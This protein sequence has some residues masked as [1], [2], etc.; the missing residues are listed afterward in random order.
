MSSEWKW[1][2]DDE[3]GLARFILDNATEWLSGPRLPVNWNDCHGSI[4]DRRALVQKLY[5]TLER[6]E[7]NYT[8]EKYHPD[9]DEQVVRTPDEILFSPREGTRLD[10]ALLFCGLCM[11]CDLIPVLVRTR[12]HAFAMVCLTH[13]RSDWNNRPVKQLT[14]LRKGL[15]K[16]A[17]LLRGW[18]D[19]GF[20]L[21]VECT[22]FARS[23]SPPAGHPEGQHRDENGLIPFGRAVE[24]GR[25]QFDDPDRELEYAIDVPVARDKGYN[26][27]QFHP[28]RRAEPAAPARARQA[29]RRAL[30]QRL[31][32]L[33]EDH[34]VASG[35]L[36]YA[37]DAVDRLRIKRRVE[38]LLREMEEVAD[39]LDRM[40]P[41][42]GG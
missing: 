6:Y 10:L 31:A 28:L 25:A 34:Q 9:D 8:P 13:R 33:T 37:R 5:E 19:G 11:G 3:K 41:G 17:D 30:E 26:S 1:L 23:R 29:R 18:I 2:K 20:Y 12:G 24:A 7:I 42:G 14:E 35:E 15:V 38:Q 40:G 32:S 39:E 4:D 21:A 27:D 36:T 16:D 22:G